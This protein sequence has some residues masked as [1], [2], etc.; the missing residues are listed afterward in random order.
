[1]IQWHEWV[2]SCP[3]CGMA[4]VTMGISFAT[5]GEI[6]LSANCAQCGTENNVASTV[7]S[8]QFLCRQADKRDSIEQ[9]VSKLIH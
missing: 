2:H 7:E 3:E 5:D 8:L 9:G 1:M 4:C 6:M